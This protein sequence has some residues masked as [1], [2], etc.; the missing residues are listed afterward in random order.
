MTYSRITTKRYGEPRRL[1]HDWRAVLTSYLDV[2]EHD[3]RA[4]YDERVQTRAA[5][6]AE[7]F[8][9]APGPGSRARSRRQRWRCASWG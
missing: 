2:L 1:V 3:A 7:R 8:G 6:M 4:S 5:E 9:E